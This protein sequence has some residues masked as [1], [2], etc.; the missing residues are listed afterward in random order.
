MGAPP[1]AE[2]RKAH[3]LQVTCVVLAKDEGP[4]LKVEAIGGET[5]DGSCWIVSQQDAIKGIEHARWS[6]F[7]LNDDGGEHELEIASTADGH[8][9]LRCKEERDAPERLLRL[10]H[11]RA[12]YW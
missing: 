10:K 2:T 8:R 9:F 7:V 5:K 3:R 12:R 6:F 4:N 1:P 11:C